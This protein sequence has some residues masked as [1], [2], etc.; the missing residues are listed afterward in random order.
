MLEKSSASSSRHWLASSIKTIAWVLASFVVATIATMVVVTLLRAVGIMPAIEAG[1]SAA[2]LWVLGL[3]ALTYVVMLVIL[4]GVP[5]AVRRQV[6]TR[7]LLGLTELLR[8]R[9]IGIALAGAVIYLL[10]AVIVMQLAALLPWVDVQQQQDL[11]VQA[12][13]PGGEIA[14]AFLLFVVIGPIA[15]ELI[16]RGY[17]YGR[18]R[19]TKAPWW[20]SVLLTSILFGA[21]H[22]QWNVGFDTLALSVVMCLTREVSGSLWPSILMH[23]LKNGV[24]FYFVF[25]AQVVPGVQ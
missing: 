19:Q 18:L 7:R 25:V 22:M 23:M 6:V 24:A 13:R 11:G 15:E 10:L 12:L 3:G 21:V 20:L 17:L 9:D 14:L 8:W 5:W 16:F 4:I 2:N 1:S